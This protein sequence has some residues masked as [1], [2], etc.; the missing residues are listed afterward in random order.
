M[1]FP[2]IDWK[3]AAKGPFAPKLRKPNVGDTPSSHDLSAAVENPNPKSLSKNDQRKTQ[4]ITI[5][6]TLHVFS[7]LEVICEGIYYLERCFLI[8]STYQNSSFNYIGT[9]LQIDSMVSERSLLKGIVIFSIIAI[10]ISSYLLYTKLTG[11]KSFCDFS[12]E[13]SCDAVSQSPYSEFPANSGIPVAGL[14]IISY[15]LF[16]IPSLL[17]LRNY[18]FT[19]IHSSLSKK[20]VYSLLTL[21]GVFG[22]LFY[23]YL[24]YLEIYVIYAI[25]PLCVVT[26]I[27]AI[28]ILG[29]VLAAGR[30]AGG[31]RKK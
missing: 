3:I 8:N 23:L 18:D 14:G 19:K 29:F 7:A 12:P 6:N 5:L 15:L 24:T 4:P 31:E 25:C 10:G 16:L 13:I 27:I 17:L 2:A 28:I 20:R 26:F 9:L 22:I 21:W 11:Y 1:G 30:K